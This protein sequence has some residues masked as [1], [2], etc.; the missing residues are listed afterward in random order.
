MYEYGNVST[1]PVSNTRL[2]EC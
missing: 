1:K 2:W